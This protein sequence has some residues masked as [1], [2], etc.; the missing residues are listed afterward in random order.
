[1][2]DIGEYQTAMGGNYLDTNMSP[3]CRIGL[4]K[5]RMR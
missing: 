2:M 4:I 3:F 5:I 1:M